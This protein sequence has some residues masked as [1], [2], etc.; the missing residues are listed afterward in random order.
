MRDIQ[1]VLIKGQY[2]LDE[3]LHGDETGIMYGVQRSCNTYIPMDA[4]QA[5]APDGDSKVRFTTFQFRD[6]AGKIKL[7]SSIIKCIATN[8][9]DLSG[10]SVVANL[11]RDPGFS[12]ADGW[13]AMLW[14][15]L[16]ALPNQKGDIKDKLVVQASLHCE[17]ED[18]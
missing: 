2:T 6:T 13:K 9:V 16:V 15:K 17:R 18:G 11:L 14:Q 8:A 1:D 7:T 10:T 4:T 12:A 3:A 5:M